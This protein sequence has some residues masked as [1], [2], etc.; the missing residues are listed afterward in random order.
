MVFTIGKGKTPGIAY[1]AQLDSILQVCLRSD[2][3]LDARQGDILLKSRQKIAGEPSGIDDPSVAD[4]MEGRVNDFSTLQQIFDQARFMK[5]R[6]IGLNPYSVHEHIIRVPKKI[7]FRVEA[8]SL[9]QF[10]EAP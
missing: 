3:P 7:L 2:A 1:S 9:H 10:D 5:S 8:R 6:Q 4:H